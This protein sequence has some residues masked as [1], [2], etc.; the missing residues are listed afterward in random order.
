MASPPL[1]PSFC[2]TRLLSHSQPS[3]VHSTA[4]QTLLLP[5]VLCGAAN[6]ATL[7]K[8]QELQHSRPMRGVRDS[9]VAWVSSLAS[10]SDRQCRGVL[11]LGGHPLSS[12]AEF[13]DQVTVIARQRGDQLVPYSTKSG[14]TLLLLHHGDFSPEVSCH[15]LWWRDWCLSPWLFPPVVI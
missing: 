4:C 14:D 15:L 2:S 13:P 7:W 12:N 9:G 10:L 5:R 1:A 11:G 6:G 8:L 3:L